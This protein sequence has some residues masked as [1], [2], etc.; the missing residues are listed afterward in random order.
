MW[1]INFPMFEYSEEEDRWVACHH[2]FTCPIDGD[3][4]KLI[5]DPEHCYAKAYDCVLNGWEIGGGSI[6]IH[7]EE[8]QEKSLRP[9]RSARKRR[10]RNS[11]SCSTLFSSALRPMAALPS[12]WIASSQ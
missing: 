3:E 4:D 2:P 10:A 5:S 8:V 11:A 6:R 7:R 9:L 12:A 1:V